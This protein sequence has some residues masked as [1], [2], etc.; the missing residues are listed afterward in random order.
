M[1]PYRQRSIYEVSSDLSF[2]QLN[3]DTPLRWSKRTEPG[4]DERRAL[5]QKKIPGVERIIDTK[6]DRVPYS[7]M[8]DAAA[9]LWTARRMFARAGVR[10]P[11]DPQ[12]D[13]FG[14]RMEIV[15]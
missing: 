13:E 6:L 5:L 10:V 7:H 1:A 11:Q 9:F 15:R 14:L 8:L 12:W 4:Q 3:D 2:Y